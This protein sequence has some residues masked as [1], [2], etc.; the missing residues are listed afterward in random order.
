[1]SLCPPRWTSGNSSSVECLFPRS[2]K[3]GGSSNDGLLFGVRQFFQVGLESPL[4]A[5]AVTVLE[6]FFEC[7]KIQLPE[8]R[9]HRIR[10]GLAYCLRA[11]QLRHASKEAHHHR[12]QHHALAQFFSKA[13]RRNAVNLLVA[14][15]VR[16][17]N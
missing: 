5:C 15:Q 11:K 12:V 10:Y 9:R 7:L 16:Y 3:A 2:R 13:C 8:T 6:S 4:P 17:A 1:M 14:V